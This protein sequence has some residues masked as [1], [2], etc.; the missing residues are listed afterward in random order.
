MVQAFT[1]IYADLKTKNL[2][3]KRHVIN[4]ECSKA[5]K[6]FTK[7]NDTKI[8]LVEPHNHSV[9]AAE[10]AVKAVNTMS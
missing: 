1:D 9:N 2:Q 7:S 3:P 6:T 5:V 4:N 10:P 8:Q